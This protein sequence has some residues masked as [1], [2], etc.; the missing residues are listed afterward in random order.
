MFCAI[1]KPDNIDDFL[2]PTIDELIRLSPESNDAKIIANRVCT[3]SLRC[4]ISDTPMRAYFKRSKGHKGYWAC[5]RCIQKGVQF[6]G[7][8]RKI[9][10]ENVAAPLRKAEDFLTYN[11]NDISE[12]NHLDPTK[13]SLFVR[14][15]FNMVTGFVIEPMHTYVG[16]AFGRRLGGF[17][18]VPNEEKIPK[19]GLSCIHN[20]VFLSDE[21]GVCCWSYEC[22]RKRSKGN[23][24]LFGPSIIAPPLQPQD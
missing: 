15:N 17:A 16:G 20:G 19:E 12:D 3:A 8:K 14:L 18:S 21:T 10:L 9:I 11:V 6:R 4:V 1:G 23:M 7:N 5:D 24:N 22:C 13:I 2:N